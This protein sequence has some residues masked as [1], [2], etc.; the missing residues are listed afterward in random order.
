MVNFCI[1]RPSLWLLAVGAVFLSTTTNSVT[2]VEANKPPSNFRVILDSPKGNDKKTRIMLKNSL[3]AKSEDISALVEKAKKEFKHIS[4]KT[5]QIATQF[6][7]ESRELV[8]K[9]KDNLQHYTQLE[10]GFYAALTV[11][12][13]VTLK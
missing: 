13:T 4:H 9:F 5:K 7:K 1:R 6:E 3:S 8:D 12:L 10:L 11:A 2:S